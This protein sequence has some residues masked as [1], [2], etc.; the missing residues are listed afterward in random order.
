MKK[1][2]YGAAAVGTVMAFSTST[3]TFAQDAVSAATAQD[4]HSI[5]EILVVAQRREESMQKVPI[6]I[7]AV[8]RDQLES[9]NITSAYDLMAAAPTLTINRSAVYAVPFL[10]GVGSSNIIL[11]DEPSVASYVDGFYQGPAASANLP[12]NNI[13]RVEVLK[14]PQGTLYG[15][16]A[17]GGLIN[18]ITSRPQGSFAARAAIGYGNFD[19]FEADGY[20]TGPLGNRV[21]ADL[22]L[23][24]RDQGTGYVLNRFNGHRVGN[25]DVFSMRGKVEMDLGDNSTLTLA[26]DYFNARDDMGT[27][28]SNE[29]GVIPVGAASGGQ[30]SDFP[31]ETYLNIDSVGSVKAWGVSSTLRVDLDAVSLVSLTQYRHYKSEN[32]LDADATS[33]DDLPAAVYPGG[34]GRQNPAFYFDSP[35]DMPYFVTQELQLLSNGDGPFSWIVGGF[36]QLSE[37]RY[38]P[39]QFF[40]KSDLAA[41]FVSIFAEGKTSSVAGFGQLSYDVGGGLRLTAGGRV[42]WERKAATGA[43]Y[44]GDPATSLPVT[45]QDK[46]RSWTSFTYRLAA[47]WQASDGLMLYASASKGFKSGTYNTNTISPTSPPVDPETLYAYEIGFKAD[48]S[49]TFRLNGAAY[50]YDYKNIQFYAQQVNVA[51]LLNAA[52]AKLYGAEVDFVW[53]PLRG[54]TLN[55]GLAWEHSEYTDF[56]GAQV[57][58]PYAPLA[59]GSP[60]YNAPLEF[61]QATYFLDAKG[62]PVVRTPE[63]T[64]NITATYDVEFP[65]GGGMSFSGNA[66][67]NSGYSFDPLEVVNQKSYTLLGASMTYRLPGDRFSIMLWGK[68]LTNETYLESVT[69]GGRNSRVGYNPP[70]TYGITLKMNIN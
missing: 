1:R 63:F 5:G 18:L 35:S 17:T 16:N 19:T 36:G 67:H 11:G 10:R 33:A 20:V 68:N 48:P 2:L 65:N 23:R 3:T 8:S 40:T 31:R 57:Y 55:G 60:D 22:S 27:S 62:R 54:F 70:R 32:I 37:E 59:N 24:F 29:P 69:S 47:D 15:R 9:A 41:P 64:G 34:V 53:R 25:S 50:Y 30:Y 66:Y 12:F 42:T 38:I 13:D 49:R 61:G 44:L 39:L 7:T 45:V 21:R 51:A 56:P 43:Q 58:L 6:A 26:A 46:A 4:D 52:G 28:Q 14:G